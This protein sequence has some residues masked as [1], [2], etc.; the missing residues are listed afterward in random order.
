MKQLLLIFASLCCLLAKAQDTTVIQKKFQVTP[1][2]VLLFDPFTGFGYGILANF[3]Y[4]LGDATTTR[5]SNSQFLALHTTR[6]QT[7][8]QTNHQIFL[9]DEKFLWQGKLQFLDWPEYTYGLGARSGDAEPVKELI[10]YRAIE[11][12]ERL[13]WRLG[14]RKNFIGPQ[15]R[16]FSSWNLS[17]D[18]A[19]SISFF[20]QKAIGNESFI[21]SGIGLHFIHDSRDNVQNAYSGI[22][23][24]LAVNPY[25]KVLGSTQNW[26]NLRIDFRKYVSFSA[27]KQQVLATR[28]LCEQAVGEV[29]YMLTPMPGRYFA[30]RG[31]VQGRYRGKT[32][33]SA[34][35]EYRWHI[36]RGL[37]AV[38]FGNISTVSEPDGNVQYLNPAAGAGIRLALSKAQRINLR[39]DYARGLNDNGGLYFHVTEAF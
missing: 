19:D 30:T 37:G 16:L 27:K 7:A 14:K 1:M 34:E 3:N 2:P 36:W 23:L 39:I 17:S 4:L 29:P 33:L 38:A 20:E 6:G 18:I 9:N 31:Y 10:S 32:F 35:A 15:Y 13:M 24:E 8:V 11:L 25:V 28:I 22:Y 12:E 21:A 26:T 5:Y